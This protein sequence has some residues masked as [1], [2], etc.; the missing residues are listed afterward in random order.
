[1]WFWNVVQYELLPEIREQGGC[2]TPKLEKLIYTLEWVRVE[3]FVGFP[4]C[5][6]G[7]PPHDRGGLANAFVVKGGAGALDDD[8]ADRAVE[9]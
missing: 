9:D 8:G 3:E 7:R 4:W 6:F 2:L 1:M 5:G